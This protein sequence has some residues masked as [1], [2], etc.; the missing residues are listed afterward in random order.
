MFCTSYKNQL[1]QQSQAL[2]ESKAMLEALNKTS[3]IIEFDLSGHIL[4]ANPNFLSTVGYS[5]SEIQGKHHRI[6]M[7]DQDANKPEYA[8]FWQTLSRGQALSQRFRRKQKNGDVIWLEASYN[9]VIDASGKAYKVVKFATNITEQVKAEIEA[10]AQIAAIH[11]VMAV[12]EFDSQGNILTANDNF[13]KTMGYSLS[14][15][16]GQHHRIFA[17]PDYVQSSD[18]QNFWTQ[19]RSGQAF[20]GTYQRFGK[21]GREVWLEASYN[22]IKDC[23]GK[24]CKIIKYATDIGSNANSQLL[25]RVIKDA[26]KVILAIQ[27]GDLTA[28]MQVHTDAK[29][30][31]MYDKNIVQLVNAI[32]AMS[33]KLKSVIGIAVQASVSVSSS[34]A[35]VKV[36]AHQLSGSM[37]AQAAALENTS[38][39]MR[40]MNE[41]I[42]T[43][44]ANAQSAS[45][46]AQDV[47]GKSR[48]GAQVMGQ[49]LD[50]MNQIQESSHKIA[51]IVTLIDGIAFQTNLLALNAAVEAARAGEHGRGFAVVA[52]E[53]RSLAQKSA[54][55]AKDIKKLIDETVERVNQG[56]RLATQSGEVLQSITEAIGSVTSKV[57]EIATASVEQAQGIQQVNASIAQIEQV[58]QQ[59]AALVEETSAAAESMSEQAQILQE[60]MAFF[61]TGQAMPAI[62][63]PKVSAN[64]PTQAALPKPVLASKTPQ[65]QPGLVKNS[66]KIVKKDDEWDDF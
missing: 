54:E 23:D 61:K 38:N 45:Q 64:A 18:Y 9:P 12:I 5:L 39:S 41:V 46:V 11:K 10:K 50:A 56:S 35:E 48:Q 32:Q 42:Q 37:Q 31:S 26:S 58:S 43:N 53:V 24:V 66:P 15:L 21:N 2:A 6:F 65:K 34:S 19:L 59:N 40:Q 22:P 17:K 44:T 30:P 28:S 27:E 63:R 60:D 4:N 14:E 49:T 62:S 33:S 57:S 20:S 3:A 47:Q 55:A 8:Q 1:N 36:S 51:D 16:Q 29:N 13:C 52:G 25:E 7:L